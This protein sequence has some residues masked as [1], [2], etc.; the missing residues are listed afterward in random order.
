MF[1][2]LCIVFQSHLNKL[3]NEDSLKCIIDYKKN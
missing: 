1:I 2:T 3:C